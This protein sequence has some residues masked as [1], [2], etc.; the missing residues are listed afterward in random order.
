MK[1]PLTLLLTL[2]AIAVLS[3]VAMVSRQKLRAPQEILDEVRAGLSSGELD[4]QAGLRRLDSALRRAEARDTDLEGVVDTCVELRLERGHILRDIGANE[5][6]RSEYQLVLDRYRPDDFAVRLLLVQTDIEAGDLIGALGRLERLLEDQPEYGP[7]WVE[8]GRMHL[9]LAREALDTCA[10]RSRDLLA[11]VDSERAAELLERLAALDATDPARTPTVLELRQLF[12]VSEEEELGQIL[13]LC[14]VASEE[15]T[16]ARQAYVKSFAFGIDPVAVTG[17]LKILIPSGRDLEAIRFGTLTTR[18]TGQLEST[19]ADTE[20]G[21]LLVQVLADRGDWNRAADLGA[22]WLQGQTALDAEFLRT[23]CLVL[24]RSK[25][26]QHMSRAAN[27]LGSIGSADDEVLTDLY[28]GFAYAS[29][30]SA[31]KSRALQALTQFA[32]SQVTDPFPDARAF[33]WREIAKMHRERGDLALERE[34]IQAVVKLAPNLDGELWLRR[35]EIQLEARYSGYLLPLA[36]WAKAM[37]LLPL[38]TDELMPQFVTLGERALAAQDRSIDLL[39][40]E[41]RDS[42]RTL[43]T[44]DYDSYSLYRL[45]QGRGSNNNYRGQAALASRLLNQL[46]G[47]L[48]ALDELIAARLGQGNRSEFVDLVVERVETAGLDERS[49]EL[50]AQIDE[51]ELDASQILRLMIVDS[52]G[53]GRLT[54]ARWMHERGETGEALRALRAGPG[55]ERTDEERLFGAEMMMEAGEYAKALEWLDEIAEESA[56]TAEKHR[57]SLVCILSIGDDDRLRKLL[58]GLVMAKELAEADLLALSDLVLRY[59]R[60]QVAV[61][62]LSEPGGQSEAGPG[63]DLLRRALI[64]THLGEL[65]AAEDLIDRAEP[66][67]EDE[68]A[69]VL[70][71]IIDSRREN[72]IDCGRTAAGMLQRGGEEEPRRTAL[73][74]LF[75]GRE[76]EALEIA[77]FG[78]QLAPEIFEWHLIAG[79][80]N[81]V[82][83]NE[84]SI[85]ANFGKRALG[86]T[87]LFLG[88]GVTGGGS[89]FDPRQVAALLLAREL[90][91]LSPFLQ[92]EFGEMSPAARG[93][94][95]PGLLGASLLEQNDQLAEADRELTALTS[96]FPD[97]RAIWERLENAYLARLPSPDHPRLEK[98]RRDRL[99]AYATANPRGVEGALL[100]ADRAA[101]AGDLPEALRIATSAVDR[102]SGWSEARLEQA[103]I[104]T[105]MRN[106]EPALEAW[107]HLVIDHAGPD[108]RLGVG[109]LIEMLEEALRASPPGLDP[110][111]VIITLREVALAHPHDPR[112]PLALARMDLYGDPLNPSIGIERAWA[113]LTTF[114]QDHA[115]VPLEDLQRG[116]T[117][118]WARFYVAMDPAEAE[119]FIDAEMQLLPG[120]VELWGL[121]GRVQRELGK[122]RSSALVLNR[123]GRMAE[124]PR[125][126]LE[127]ARTFLVSGADPRLVAAPLDAL[128]KISR[129]P[130]TLDSKLIRVESLLDRFEESAWAQALERLEPLWDERSPGSAPGEFARL[131]ELYTRALLLRGEDGDFQRALEVLDE[132]LEAAEPPYQREHFLSLQGVARSLAGPVQ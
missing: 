131:A 58:T 107:R 79:I 56:Y 113:R 116:A 77:E 11:T 17:Y 109:G 81:L 41:L 21:K 51:S 105:T 74:Y 110:Q 18:L 20:A 124:D 117:G 62:L 67:I 66:F 84:L 4:P 72:W 13:E 50:L 38:R 15:M 52:M 87:A 10:E 115:G 2:A 100:R 1:W 23:I 118:E 6:A 129:K 119:E 5:E 61:R 85:P 75:G 98:L 94:L 29:S 47:F 44:R 65:E 73:L 42:G 30:Q 25:R 122:L 45:A 89:T 103:R 104:L 90:P 33:V 132:S 125:L 99:T 39:E 108:A 43:P 71:L 101:R 22:L 26:W 127:L 91:T 60:P 92:A 88:A 48:P 106:W 49:R 78:A 130:E 70:R 86:Q 24:Y 82:L 123:A 64:A 27:D 14:D 8:K 83:E 121:L 128:V 76:E 120:D 112:P 16:E 28:R 96:A 97:C 55:Q 34:A 102:S 35:S 114:R 46:P 31:D 68:E 3:V 37:S 40:R 12:P 7:A 93:K 19:A 57:H 69:G 9:S 59:G 111:T 95:W 80:A 32:R 54:V 126:K 63:P 53:R 36:S